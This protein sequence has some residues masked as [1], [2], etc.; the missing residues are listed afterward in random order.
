MDVTFQALEYGADDR[1]HPAEYGIAG[2]TAAGWT[3]R[4]NQAPH[5]ELGRGYRLLQSVACGVCSTDLD[6]RF[7]PFPL[8]QITG[9][10]VVAVDEDGRRH[11]VEINA[12]HHARGVAAACPFCRAGLPTH[13]PDRLV[14]GIDSLPGGFGPYVLAPIH[15]AIPLPDAIPTGAAVLI[16][17]FAAALHAVTTIAPQ[18]GQTIAVLGPRRLGLLVVAALGAYCRRRGLDTRILALSRHPRLLGLAHHFGATHSLL[19]EGDGERLSGPLADVVIDTTGNP[20]GLELALRLARREV[21][22]KTTC[23]QP[24]AGLGHLT[25]LVVDELGIER[26]P[27]GAAELARALGR[28][29]GQHGAARPRIAWLTPHAVPAWLTEAAC[30]IKAASAREALRTIEAEGEQESLPRADAAVVARAEDA[31]AAIR[32]ETQSQRSLVRPRG[33]VFIHPEAASPASPLLTAALGRGLKLTSSRCGDFHAALELMAHDPMLL[34]LG[35]MLIT[36]RLPADKLDA[37]FA[38]AR[39]KESIKV[40][41]EH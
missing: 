39:G 12:S 7:L 1:F 3:I 4:R 30:V 5:L 38:A 23:G 18:A 19:V 6:R 37:A 15:A 34:T 31:D 33:K 28:L 26:F 29:G 13:C 25:E 36:H 10:E 2:S 8:P 17:P 27:E 24:A 21:H 20:Q 14:L 9:H 35:D 40:V 16:E 11:V 41:I 32:P 22:L